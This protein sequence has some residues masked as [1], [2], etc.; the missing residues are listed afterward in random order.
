MN[1]STIPTFLQ[2]RLARRLFLLFVLCALVPIALLAAITHNSVRG[3]LTSDTEERLRQASRLLG[4]S[5]Q[6]RLGF[7]EQALETE[8]ATYRLHSATKPQAETTQ[9]E[10]N[11]SGGGVR[12]AVDTTV[13]RDRTQRWRWLGIL[14]NGQVAEEWLGER[15]AAHGVTQF[16]AEAQR[17]GRIAVV[18]ERTRMDVSVDA[19]GAHIVLSKSLVDDPTAMLVGEVLPDYLWSIGTQDTLPRGTALTVVSKGTVL[20]TTLPELSPSVVETLAAQA[21]AQSTGA[22]EWS[23]GQ[24]SSLAGFWSLPL[25]FDYGRDAWILVLSQD[26]ADALAPIRLF[27]LSFVLI[28]VASLGAI[29]LMSSVQIRR[30]LDPLEALH[31]ATRRLANRDFTQPVVVQSQD[32]VGE[33]ARSFNTMTS[34]LDRQFRAL[35]VSSE[36]DRAVLSSWDVSRIVEVVLARVGDVARVS[37]AAVLVLD[38][39]ESASGRVYRRVEGDGVDKAPSLRVDVVTVSS[40]ARAALTALVGGTAVDPAGS[41]EWVPYC[42]SAEGAPATLW[43]LR[44]G[45]ECMGCLVVESRQAEHAEDDPETCARLADQLA[46]AVAN[47][48]EM[49]GRREAEGGLRDANKQLQTALHELRV[50]QKHMVEQERLRALGEMA[51]GITHD[52]NNALYPVIGFTELMLMHP[53]ELSNRDK[54]VERLKDIN[55]AATD[56]AKIVRRLR[57]FYRTRDVSDVAVPVDLNELI[58]QTVK[59]TQPKWREQAYARG[60]TVEVRTDLQ[61]LK[62]IQ[63]DESELR[64]VFTNLLFNAVDAIAHRGRITFRTSMEAGQAQVEVEDTGCG[65]TEEVRQRCL[66]PFFSTKGDK[67]TGLGLPMVYGIIRRAGGSLDIL[68][69]V[70]RGTTFR[71]RFPTTDAIVARKDETTTGQLPVGWRVLVVDDDLLVGSVTEEYVKASGLAVELVPNSLDALARLRTRP[72]NLVIADQAMP[73]VNGSDLALL[74]KKLSPNTAV[75]ILSGANNPE[76]LIGE[77]EGAIDARLEKPLTMSALQSVLRTLAQRAAEPPPQ[78]KA[79]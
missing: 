15:G 66:E 22:L 17:T 67:G 8:S 37:H 25:M 38:R 57:D 10:S 43:P 77:L 46:V 21:S 18:T 49:A 78:A 11:G 31:A 14:R 3:R 50:A 26:A 33:L 48:T 55:L 53:D 24:G 76:P 56:A 70:G 23:D 62:P 6:E 64:E 63:G 44:R 5:V 2:S 28:C 68:S 1:R 52:F 71:L 47:A 45:V 7:L 51:S 60:M 20:A 12:Q 65:M 74:T 19:D 41:C 72:F 79:A 69:E 27:T 9:K 29:V 13:G 34:E 30:Q 36:I 32:E 61:S 16:V 40:E 73:D 42:L 75:V 58:K 4:M 54:V 35:V 59:L 39:D